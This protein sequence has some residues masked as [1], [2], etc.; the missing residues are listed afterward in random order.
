MLGT[1]YLMYVFQSGLADRSLSTAPYD[2]SAS[3]VGPNEHS[4]TL[5]GNIYL[6]DQSNAQVL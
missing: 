3:H 2:E 4:Q 5:D 1:Y 6:Y